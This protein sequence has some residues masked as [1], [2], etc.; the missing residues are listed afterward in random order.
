M[1]ILWKSYCLYLSSACNSVNERERCDFTATSEVADRVR[2]VKSGLEKSREKGNKWG[3]E[4]KA[5][6]EREREKE[7]PE[8]SIQSRL[9]PFVPMNQS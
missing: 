3:G 1:S 9:L 7:N 2:L 6:K 8:L 4:K 5:T